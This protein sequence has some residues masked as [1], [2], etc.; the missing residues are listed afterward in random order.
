MGS[1]QYSMSARHVWAHAYAWHCC[2]GN[3]INGLPAFRQF[4]SRRLL[5]LGA[6]GSP[7]LQNGLW[8]VVGVPAVPLVPVQA[9]HDPLAPLR[10]VW[11]WARGNVGVRVCQIMVLIYSTVSKHVLC[12]VLIFYRV[13][14]LCL[15]RV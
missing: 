15:I 1:R 14:Q 4:G 9:L 10:D 13:H 5:C 11:G 12:A 6:T 2:V 7:V 3:F 8:G